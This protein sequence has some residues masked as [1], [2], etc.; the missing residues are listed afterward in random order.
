M[1][2]IDCILHLIFYELKFIKMKNSI[3]YLT[4]FI[5]LSLLFFYSPLKGQDTRKYKL[6]GFKGVEIG[7][8]FEVHLKKS[9]TFY[10]NAIGKNEDLEELQ[11]DI[12]KG[13]LEVT[14]KRTGRSWAFNWNR[15]G[16]ITLQIGMPELKEAEFT[17]ASKLLMSGFHNEEDI[18]LYFSGASKAIIE[19]IDAEKLSLELSGASKIKISGNVLKFNLSSSGASSVEAFPLVSR[20]ADIELSGAS[21]VEIG[22]K[23]SLNVNASGA[24]KV[25]YKGNPTISRDLSGAAVVRRAE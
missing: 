1:Q 18:K 9:S 21:K 6:S 4:A 3:Y 14:F 20:D 2:P 5:C 11:F 10:V 15:Y 19:D 13:V 16:K 23:N 8:A 24:A 12:N 22:V 7:G 25:V 17:G